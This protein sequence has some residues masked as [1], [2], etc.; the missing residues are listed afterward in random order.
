MNKIETHI[1][2]YKKTIEHIISNKNSKEAKYLT[3]GIIQTDFEHRNAVTDNAMDV[4]YLNQLNSE[5]NSYHWKDRNKARQ[6]INQ[7]LQLVTDG[8][9]NAIRPIIYELA[10][11]MPDDEKPKETLG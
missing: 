7:G 8:T 2:E 9:T 1:K 10:D 3:I 11:L 5:Y 4:Q 6:L